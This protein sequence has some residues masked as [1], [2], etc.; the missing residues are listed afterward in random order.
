MFY[1]KNRLPIIFFK[2][3]FE[4]FFVLYNMTLMLDLNEIDD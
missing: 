3:K 4:I 1:Y 2:L